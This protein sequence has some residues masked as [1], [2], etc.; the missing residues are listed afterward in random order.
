[1]LS[2]RLPD[3]IAA[4]LAAF[5]LVGVAN[6]LI[7]VGAILVAGVLGASPMLANILGYAVGLAVSFAL[8]SQVTFQ[9]RR[10][11]RSTVVRFLA[12]FVV[13]FMLNLAVVKVV[14]ELATTHT[15]LASLAGTPLY[16]TV[17]YLL[18]EY[19]VFQRSRDGN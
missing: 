3:R 17:F 12:A 14:T 13:A 2:V 10:I 19:W 4:R 1:M 9:T 16:M 15:L 11:D 5:S 8:N 7:G 6:T 18:C